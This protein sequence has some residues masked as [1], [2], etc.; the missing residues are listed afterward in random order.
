M[1]KTKS[2]NIMSLGGVNTAIRIGAKLCDVPVGSLVRLYWPQ[3]WGEDDSFPMTTALVISGPYKSFLSPRCGKVVLECVA[4]GVYRQTEPCVA[5]V[6]AT[7]VG[8]RS[9]VHVSGIAEIVAL[10]EDWQ[11]NPMDLLE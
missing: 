1:V 10:P 3:H 9:E 2:A 5:N 8:R 4:P 11:G 7:G 6:P